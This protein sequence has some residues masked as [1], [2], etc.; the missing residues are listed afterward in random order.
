MNFRTKKHLLRDDFLLSG[1]LKGGIPILQHHRQ[2]EWEHTGTLKGIIASPI[3][4]IANRNLMS[5]FSLL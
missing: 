1:V 5:T 2:C 3:I 4:S